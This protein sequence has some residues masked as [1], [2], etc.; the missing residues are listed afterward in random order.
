MLLSM[1][2]RYMA[3]AALHHSLYSEME[4]AAHACWTNVLQ[5]FV[6]GEGLASQ[7]AHED[8]EGSLSRVNHCVLVQVFVV[9]ILERSSCAGEKR[10]LW[11][12]VL[13]HRLFPVCFLLLLL[14][15][16]VQVVATGSC[17]F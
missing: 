14:Y 5:V 2:C 10:R 8:P 15:S 12:T 1:L 4:V 11:V 6:S 17:F 7:M 16:E 13:V 9:Q 3:L